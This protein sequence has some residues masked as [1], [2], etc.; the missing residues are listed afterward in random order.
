MILH[1]LVILSLH[2]YVF[3]ICGR[4]TCN[5]GKILNHSKLELTSGSQTGVY[6]SIRKAEFQCW[7][8]MNCPY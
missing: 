1:V 8:H 6:G 4:I 3:I 5:L 2:I 7:H